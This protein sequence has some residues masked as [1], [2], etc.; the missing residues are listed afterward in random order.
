MSALRAAAALALCGCVPPYYSGVVDLARAE[1]GDVYVDI[2]R[3]SPAVSQLRS[4][5]VI[6]AP[7]WRILNVYDDP[8]AQPSFN[9]TVREVRVLARE[10]G[11]WSAEWFVTPFLWHTLEPTTLYARIDR[12]RGEVS[13]TTLESAWVR[14]GQWV[15][16]LEPLGDGSRTL[17]TSYA[18]GEFK[19]WWLNLVSAEQKR[20]VH[21]SIQNLRRIVALAKYGA[22]P[23]GAAAARTRVVVPGFRA[24]GVPEETVRTLARV[25][26]EQLTRNG[27][28]TIITQDEAAALLDYTKQ[29]QLAGCSGEAGCTID[30]GRALEAERI[31]HGSIGRV[32][33]TW[34]L[35]ASLLRLPGGEVERRVSGEAASDREL[36]ERVRAAA[37][38]LRR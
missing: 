3:V 25:F 26:A 35:S 2:V 7:A 8:E 13:F 22:Q 14:N 4:V 33:E 20:A 11:Y 16:K 23:A 15:T 32:G 9:T 21:D 17:F 6:D 37:D 30:I 24:E 28:W 19:V 36:L 5:A 31:V 38:E 18:S 12:A 27:A 1:R 34:V 29:Q 10:P